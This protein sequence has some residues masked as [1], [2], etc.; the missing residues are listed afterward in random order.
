MLI[1]IMCSIVL[2]IFIINIIGCGTHKEFI[3][4][5][6]WK[7][8]ELP[9]DKVVSI[10]LKDG[11][12]YDLSGISMSISSK[13]TKLIGKTDV[14]GIRVDS[15]STYKEIEIQDIQ[16]MWTKKS[17]ANPFISAF[18]FLPGFLLPYLILLAVAIASGNLD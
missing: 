6:D 13:G 4:K 17:Y 3:L 16:Y 18:T 7:S 12:T 5:R 10:I 9:K 8:D 15:V 11:S 1:K 2:M 14:V